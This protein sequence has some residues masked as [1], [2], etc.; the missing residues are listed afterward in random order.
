ME[1]KKALILAGGKGERLRPLTLK[2][3]KTLIEVKGKPVLQW[4]IELVKRFGVREVVL[5]VGYKHKQIE[6]YFGDGSKLGVKLIYNVEKDFLGTAGALKLA[7]DFFKNEKKF[8]M[9]NSDECKIIDF[10]S[11]N[12]VFDRRK[13]VAA[14]ALTPIDYTAAGGIVITEGEKLTNF[15][16]KP[17]EEQSG[18]KLINAGAYILG[19]EIFDYI[20]AEKIVSIEKDVFPKLIDGGKLFGI[21]CIKQFLQI[22]TFERLKKARREW[23]GI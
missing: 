15:D 20:P 3:P 4:N 5:A 11:L 2:T 6:E 7:E 19:P 1:I 13:A 8:I 10:H 14:V 23:K 17:E 21:P 18:K 12:A 22:D 9:M 16:E